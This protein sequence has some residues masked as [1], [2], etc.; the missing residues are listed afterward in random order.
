MA[1]SLPYGEFDIAVFVYQKVS[2]KAY[3]KCESC[4]PIS[5]QVEGIRV[6]LVSGDEKRVKYFFSQSAVILSCLN[7]SKFVDFKN[8]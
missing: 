6:D 4:F 5:L 8:V 1:N 2:S 7:S 3:F